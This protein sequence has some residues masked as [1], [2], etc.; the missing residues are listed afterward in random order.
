MDIA[1]LLPNLLYDKLMSSVS[2]KPFF[3]KTPRSCFDKMMLVIVQHLFSQE[4]TF[5]D[6]IKMSIERAHMNRNIS[7]SDFDE[8]VRLFIESERELKNMCET[9]TNVAEPP[10]AVH[11]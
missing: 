7:R 6:N 8:Y 5:P 4:R 1:Y 3:S 10:P 11:L 9:P 2:L